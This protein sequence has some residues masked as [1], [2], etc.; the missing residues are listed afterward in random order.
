KPKTLDDLAGRK[1][2][3]PYIALRTTQC[4][5]H[6]RHHH[7]LQLLIPLCQPFL[8]QDLCS[9]L[10]GLEPQKYFPPAFLRILNR[11]FFYVINVFV[12]DPHAVSSIKKIQKEVISLLL[13]KSDPF[14]SNFSYIKY[15]LLLNPSGQQIYCFLNHLCHCHVRDSSY[16]IITLS[17]RQQDSFCFALSCCC[18]HD[19]CALSL[20][21]I[22]DHHTDRSHDYICSPRRHKHGLFSRSR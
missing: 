2:I 17:H 18:R 16:Y 8:W 4:I 9:K 12:Y 13:S 11:L 7:R 21:D 15:G 3:S 20:H 10:I 5:C 19:R 6:E 1:N 22:C 14:L